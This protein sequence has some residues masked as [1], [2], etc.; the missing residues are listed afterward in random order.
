MAQSGEQP[1]LAVA[2]LVQDDAD[3]V[4]ATLNAAAPVADEVLVVSTVEGSGVSASAAGTFR[5]VELDESDDLAAAGNACLE[6]SKSDWIL[7][8][9]AGETVAPEDARRLRQF[10]QREASPQTAYMLVVRTPPPHPQA[11]GE[12]VG[13]V[14]LFP[15]NPELRWTHRVRPSLLP[16]LESLSMTVDG[17]PERIDRGPEE[18]DAHRKQRLAE[19]NV[20]LAEQEIEEQGTSA[21]MLSC[22]GDAYQTLDDPARAASCYHRALAACEPASADYLEATYG[23]LA[24][25]ENLPDQTEL[26]M[27]L[28]LEALKTYPLDAQLLCAMGGYL[29]QRQ[30]LELAARSYLTAYQYGRIRPDVWHVA[31]IH[32]IA[33]ICGS[34]ALQLND[35]DEEAMQWLTDALKV[36][37][38]SDRIRRHVVGLHVKHGRARDALEVLRQ[39]PHA[40]P[41]PEA[42][43]TAIRG[44][45]LATQQNWVPAEAYL[46]TAYNAG[47][48]DPLCLRWYAITLFATNQLTLAPRV[49]DDWRALEPQNPEIVRYQEMLAEVAAANETAQATTAGESELLQKVSEKA[50][51]AETAE[52]DPAADADTP[53]A[54]TPP[55]T[56]AADGNT[57][58]GA[59]I[60][61]V[62]GQREER[63]PGITRPIAPMSH[64]LPTPPPS[65]P[66]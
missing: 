29:Q 53:P 60:R 34:L 55:A 46:R 36:H 41:N 31:E 4:A 26:Q 3:P 43:R 8:L 28:T 32:E 35:Q 7:W 2:I 52:V 65:V 17:L 37:P 9:E 56:P 47:C 33:A 23:L 25:L 49:L 63:S 10:V 40:I 42:L 6:Q 45:S 16:H 66:Q 22:L 64:G 62:D 30:R 5:T 59:A 18:H 21:R 24:T 51:A 14:R 13:E 57:K 44:A 58:G 12:Q 11:E 61:R 50:D 38:D 1:T 39:T 54:E 19:R 48:R 27:Q 15:R 20:R